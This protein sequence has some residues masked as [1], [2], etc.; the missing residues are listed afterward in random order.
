MFLTGGDNAPVKLEKIV[1]KVWENGKPNSAA[2]QGNQ[3]AGQVFRWAWVAIGGVACR[4][5][6]V[7]AA[8][9]G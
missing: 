3:P 9:H 7:G 4:Y 6:I 5:E 1:G 8:D 2:N